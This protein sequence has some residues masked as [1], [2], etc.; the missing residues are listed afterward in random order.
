MQSDR[1]NKPRGFAQLS[2]AQRKYVS[3]KGGRK[4]VPKGLALLPIEEAR[5]IQKRGGLKRQDDRRK[6]K[7]MEKD[8]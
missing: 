7:E 1:P 6:L 2:P 5:K 3:A 8:G 4:R